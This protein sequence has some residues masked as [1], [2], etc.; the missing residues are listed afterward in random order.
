MIPLTAPHDTFTERV[1]TAETELLDHTRAAILVPV[2]QEV[3]AAMRREARR[4][5]R[6]EV[7]CAG[8]M[9][10]TMR[11]AAVAAL[12]RGDERG[13]ALAVDVGGSTLR[14]ALLELKGGDAELRACQKWAITDDVKQLD[15]RTLFRWFGEHIKRVLDEAA[16]N[17][18]DAPLPM[19]LSWS[20]PIAQT[21][22]SDAGA[23]TVLAM[24]KGYGQVAAEMRGWDLRAAF[25]DA[26]AKL[27]VRNVDLRAVVNDT[28][29][30]LLAHAYR[31]RSTR[32]ALVLGTG[33]NAS[34]LLAALDEDTKD[35]RPVLINTEM[36]LFGGG[37]LPETCW[38]RAVDAQ[39]D[40]PGF[41]P[42]ETRV[43]GMYLGELSRLI[44]LDAWA[45]PPQFLSSPVLAQKY[46]LRTEV[47]SRAE[48]LWDS[49]GGGAAAARAYL[50]E[51]LGAGL[52]SDAAAAAMCRVFRAVSTRAAALTAAYIVALAQLVARPAEPERGP[53]LRQPGRDVI[54]V[55]YTGSTIELYPGFA[56]RCQQF[57]D[58]LCQE[59]AL[60]CNNDSPGTRIRLVLEKSVDST[61]YGPAV[62]SIIMRD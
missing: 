42:L 39:A 24:G 47:M 18:H 26:L 43:G 31:K 32:I 56:A 23:A 54:T 61:T 8:K 34:A 29:A 15:G 1:A 44:I 46:G 17:L 55:A 28:V 14:V 4:R 13:P 2:V 3:A 33:V 53:E 51:Q 62:A 5:A 52:G 7:D 27:G 50:E 37:V 10:L 12:P 21:S 58:T 45:S 60:L 57:L 38:D 9:G 41:Q 59:E 16:A 49:R 6:G 36:S 40:R 25:M 11:A 35:S 30:A 22:S 48:E 20:F 19:G